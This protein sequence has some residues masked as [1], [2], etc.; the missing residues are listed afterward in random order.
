MGLGLLFIMGQQSK[1]GRCN[2]KKID[3]QQIRG[4]NK[5]ILSNCCRHRIWVLKRSRKKGLLC[6]QQVLVTPTLAR[7]YGD[8][9]R[10]RTLTDLSV[11]GQALG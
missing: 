3:G 5:S 6:E 9:Y 10:D 1:Y 11:K 2:K 8:S 4:R 7:G